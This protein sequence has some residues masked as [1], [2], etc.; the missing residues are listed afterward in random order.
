MTLGS[1]SGTLMPR[2]TAS[3]KLPPARKTSAARS[4]AGLPCAHVE[5][6]TAFASLGRATSED[7]ATL[8]SA[9]PKAVAPATDFMKSRRSTGSIWT[10]RQIRNQESG[11]RIKTL[12]VLDSPHVRLLLSNQSLG[13]SPDF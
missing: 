10:P 5:R 2:S 9:D 7:S 4:F 8:K 6:N 3:S 12:F 1:F 13:F 11:V